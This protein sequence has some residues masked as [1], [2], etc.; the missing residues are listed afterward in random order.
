MK[1]NKRN[2]LHSNANCNAILALILFCISVLTATCGFYS[3]HLGLTTFYY[4]L[5]FTFAAGAF[6][7]VV[8]YMEDRYN[9]I[10]FNELIALG[11]ARTPNQTYR[12]KRLVSK[13]Y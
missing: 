2:K 5:G 8:G 13:G 12:L 1:I 10:E 11:D 6:T 7:T 3:S 4:I 9:T